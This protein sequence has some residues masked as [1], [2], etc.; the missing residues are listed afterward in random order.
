[1]PDCHEWTDCQSLTAHNS[2]IFVH[3]HNIIYVICNSITPT[4]WKIHFLFALFNTKSHFLTAKNTFIENTKLI[5]QTSHSSI[6]MCSKTWNQYQCRVCIGFYMNNNQ[7]SK[8]NCWWFKWIGDAIWPLTV[9]QSNWRL[10]SQKR[11][12]M[13]NLAQHFVNKQQRNSV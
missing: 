3:I 10:S 7:I 2:P 6:K 5:E 12:R 4:N 1:M 11:Q 8:S 9:E 13:T